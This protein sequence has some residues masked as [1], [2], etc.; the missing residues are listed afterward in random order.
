MSELTS[1][2]NQELLANLKKE[3]AMYDISYTGNAT[4]AT[5]TKKI[6]AYK[7]ASDEGL[8]EVHPAV[9]LKDLEKA[10]RNKMMLEARK[11]VRVEI[12]CND[13]K[14]RVRGQI[15]RSVGNRYVTLR[16]VIPL[17][18][19]THV[20]QLILT[21]MKESKFLTFV[22][23]KVNGG[24]TA[25]PKEVFTYNIR[26]LDPLTVEGIKRIQIRQQADVAIGD[27]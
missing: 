5:L 19:P 8:L 16:K 20:P 23:K 9:N 25:I 17:D 26:E 18:I 2:Q 27:N 15:F 3:C 6:K 21:N 12:T 1:E 4:V 22:K 13:P 14:I 11:L 24:E 10:K 7:E